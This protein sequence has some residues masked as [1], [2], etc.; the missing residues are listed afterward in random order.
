LIGLFDLFFFSRYNNFFN[1][2]FEGISDVFE[3]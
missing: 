3:K 2:L 1:I